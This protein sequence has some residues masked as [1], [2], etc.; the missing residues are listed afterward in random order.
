MTEQILIDTGDKY[1]LGDFPK[2]R[3]SIIEMSDM[4]QSAYWTAEEVSMQEDK[5]QWDAGLIKNPD[6]TINKDADAVAKKFISNVLAFFAQSDGIVL[7]NLG[8]RFLSEVQWPE[9][10]YF[11]TFQMMMENTHSKSYGLMIKALISDS[12]ERHRLFHAI[13]TMPIVAKKAQWAIKYIKSSDD[14]AVRLVAFA[15]VEGVFFSGSFC[16]IFWL[17][18]LGLMPGLCEYNRMISRDEGIHTDFACLLLK[19]FISNKPLPATVEKIMDDAVNI[20][21]EFITES[22]SCSMIG[23]NVKKMSNYIKWCANRLL[24]QLGYKKMYDVRRCPFEFMER[25]NMETKANMHERK[26]LEYASAT[27]GKTEL[28]NSVAFDADF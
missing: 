1:V 2:E 9:I 5:K 10:R 3:A 22:I 25:I 12:K 15:I 28:D 18:D 8:I 13:D 11:Y 4:Q 24:E 16:A 20:E 6:G 17:K 27:S 23:M 19:Q 26:T 14:F 7:E 21:I